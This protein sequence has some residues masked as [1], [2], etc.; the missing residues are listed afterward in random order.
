MYTTLSS[1]EIV[2][3]EDGFSE[4][5]GSCDILLMSRMLRLAASS[6]L[7]QSW[8]RLDIIHDLLLAR[9]ECGRVSPI[10]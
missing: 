10:A 6:K 8:V 4:A 7:E 9:L 5:D 3:R 2:S 1:E